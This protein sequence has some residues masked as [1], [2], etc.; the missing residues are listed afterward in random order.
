MTISPDDVRRLLDADG[1]A[2][3]V[4]IEGR[5]EVVDADQL[6]SDEYRGALEVTTRDEL[7]KQTGGA[8]LSDR[9]LAEQADN[10]NV[11]VDDLGG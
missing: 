10:L 8:E 5:A 4:V 9:E 3:L 7:V 1:D 6:G 11:A 2:T